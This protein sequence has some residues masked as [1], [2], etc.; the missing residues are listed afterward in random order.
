M[1]K[2]LGLIFN[3]WVLLAVL[4]LAVA[5][6]IW[7]VGPLLGIGEAHPLETESSRW[8]AIGVIA[9]LCVLVMA[10]K[11]WRARRGNSA[12]V[13]QLMTSASGP[14]KK[15]ADSP[16]LLAVRQRFEQ[17][18]HTLK[19]ARFGAG[20]LLQGWS[21][22][23]GGRYLYE[24]PWYLIIGAP[25]SGKTTALHNCGLKFPLAGNVGDHA[26]RGVGGTRHC[27]WWF[28]DQAVLIDT[29]GR[30][31]TQDSDR[32]SD[33]ATWGGF[34]GMLKRSRPRQP[35]NGVLVTV[36]V[37]D[38]LTKSV[39]ERR[40]HAATVRQRLQE[41]HEHLSIRFPIY[42][43]VTKSDLLAG[44]MDYFALLD[45]EQRATPW[46]STFP[47]GDGS[48]Q[49][50]QRFGD[51]F[52]AL[53]QRLN[54]GLIERLQAERDP[55]RRARIYGFPGQ[56]A[57]LR[58][59]LQEFLETVFSPSPYEAEPLLRGVYFVSG[60]QEGTPIDR[61]L[62][63]IARSY[64]LERAVIA[65]NQA[66]GK[67]YF[68]TRLLGEVVFAESGLAGTNLQWERRRQWLACGGYATAG[69]VTVAA[70]S[71]WTVSYVQ[72]R[73]YVDHVAQRV[74]QVRQLVQAAP[75]RASPDVLP[76]LPPLVATR[77]LPAAERDVP[78]SLG[79][80]LYQ[81][82]KLDSAARQAYHRM[83]VDAVLP[84][85]G[86]RVEE[87]LRQAGTAPD[88]L[89]EA[90]K[91]YLMLHD[92]QHFD[93]DA[94]KAYVEADWDA[95]L[96][97]SIDAEQRAQ[98]SEHLDALL[99]QGAVVSPL[100][101]DKALIDFHRARLATVTLPQR[102]YNR[103]R[104]QGLGSEFPEFTV[105]RA[106][107]NNAA[108][109]F[110]R[111][112]GAPLTKGVPGLFSYDGYYRGFQK[113]VKRVAQQ[114]AEEQAWVL[115]VAETPKDAATAVRAGDQLLDDVRRIYLNEY[116]VT[117]EG[118]IADVRLLPMTSLAQS[119]QMARLLSA[120]D[121]PL[122]PL[123]KAMSRETT[124]LAS[125]GKNLVEKAGDRATDVLKKSRDAIADALAA[126]KTESGPRI[127]SLVDDRF[128]GLRRLVT[129][130]DGGKPP[131]D[132][133]IA[134]IGEVHLLL[135][136]VDSAVKG[137]A[138]PQPSPL[139]NK[140]KTEAAR[141]PEPMRS[142][143]DNLSASSASLSQIL[144]R[145]N[146][147]QEVRSQVGEFCQQAVA[148]RYP[149]DPRSPRDAT[150]ADF[151]LL[152]GP[153]GKIDQLFQQRLA[154]YVD[155]TTRPWRFRAVE[156][157]PLGT[158]AGT[159]PQFQR[160][161]AIRETFFP[162]G[163]TP[164]L[165]LQFKPVEM[166]ASLKQFIL[167]VDGQIVRYDHGPQ[168]P[169]SV[170][171]PGPRGTSQVRVQVSPPGSGS[172][173]GLVHDG[174]WALLRLFDRVKIEPTSV[175]ERFRATFDVDGRKAVFEITASSVRNPF[176]LR[177]LNEFACPT[178]L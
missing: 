76:V 163:N 3:R 6:V 140:V 170:Q 178:G 98:L 26:V 145:Q 120:P 136:A 59:V 74:D 146:L 96:G 115:G 47:L 159:L 85:L 31:T 122:P 4:L 135:N 33:R 151:A 158:D 80:G 49:R 13:Q 144:V 167:D 58:G 91:A 117:W 105:V 94:L 41:L 162:A 40:H 174:P 2:L 154:S 9:A 24:L 160:A 46:G 150:T 68:L 17:A 95:Q 133:T 34:L 53:L 112:S 1:K 78:W 156:G 100:P 82:P 56:F 54:D 57:G 155:T 42:L 16:D 79:F 114:L 166:D 107:G 126:K 65:P 39:A 168:I 55:Q 175:P 119:I 37:T 129:A 137:G 11:S 70:L 67:S 45:K 132:D 72:N 138:A 173:F 97:R 25:G 20:G 8:I 148:G 106:A 75:N 87:Q 165:R 62:G 102:I 71:A 153:G 128:V 23:L 164:S 152:F 38:L 147:A 149:L 131:L 177:E 139:P 29:A 5:M 69:I 30:F 118:F 60:T 77:S 130:P 172:T 50:L 104:H 157:V 171:W 127:E 73:R 142:M 14:E 113:E 108:L 12:V 169:T 116:A 143:M 93:A 110:T 101:Q 83:L 176:R 86:L 35:V 27:D 61:V 64:R 92:V 18:M 28:T 15:E 21:S 22:K 134:L 89:Y 7:I 99:A 10:W 84:R 43:L 103:M 125:S 81:G 48:A 109:V 36:S 32:E 161:Q 63:S 51:E 121:S 52:D 90:L 88:S 111:A 141:L 123:M 124:L 19:R 44:F 66:S